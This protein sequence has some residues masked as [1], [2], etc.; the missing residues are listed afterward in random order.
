MT[1][2]G[3]YK[4]PD[5]PF[6]QPEMDFGTSN[7][8]PLLLNYLKVCREIYF[9]LTFQIAFLWSSASLQELLSL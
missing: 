4:F 2:S 6:D 3:F 9:L 5:L 8:P 1:L 7:S